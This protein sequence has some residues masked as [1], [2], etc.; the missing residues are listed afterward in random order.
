MFAVF[1]I[2]EKQ[3]IAIAV[4]KLSTSTLD[5]WLWFSGSA[6]AF[7]KLFPISCTSSQPNKQDAGSD[8]YSQMLVLLHAVR[9]PSDLVADLQH[10]DQNS[11]AS[12]VWQS[13][14]SL[15]CS[16]RVYF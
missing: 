1:L 15:E 10:R 4:L 16:S 8:C 11:L 9:T 3:D 5:T 7:E 12:Q 6:D 14:S 13:S 2:F